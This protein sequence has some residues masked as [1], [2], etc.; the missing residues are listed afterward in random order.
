MG[1]KGTGVEPRE[2][3]IRVSFA[4]QGKRQKETLMVGGKPMAP[5]PANIKHATRLV[6]EIKEKIRNGVFTW[7]EYFPASGESSPVTLSDQ[8]KTWL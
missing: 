1:R 2:K 6:A 5:T 4:Y 3:S 7:A 8:L